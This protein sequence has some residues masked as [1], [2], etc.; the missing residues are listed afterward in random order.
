MT[1]AGVELNALIQHQRL[2][3]DAECTRLGGS[4]PPRSITH[5][6]GCTSLS[7]LHWTAT[8]QACRVANLTHYILM[9]MKSMLKTC[10]QVKPKTAKSS[11][12][13]YLLKGRQSDETEATRSKKVKLRH[14][15][16]PFSL[17]KT[18]LYDLQTDPSDD[19]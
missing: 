10:L 15:E 19:P 18:Q 8:M 11:F 4:L 14:G 9:K 13:F 3:V 6:R 17:R 16:T 1:S 5:V 2:C 12:R 7:R